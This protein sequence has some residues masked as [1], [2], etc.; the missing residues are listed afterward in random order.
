MID[1]IAYI[2]GEQLRATLYRTLYDRLGRGS[3][4]LYGDLSQPHSPFATLAVGGIFP[5][6]LD[7]R[8]EKAVVAAGDEA[9]GQLNMVVHAPEILSK[10][11][12][13]CTF[14]LAYALHTTTYYNFSDVSG[15]SISFCLSLLSQL[16]SMHSSIPM[17]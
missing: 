5:H 10:I 2:T 15:F 3:C 6:G 8:L 17:E 12:R 16:S 14:P 13:T 9:R 7:A 4:C 1:K 11:T